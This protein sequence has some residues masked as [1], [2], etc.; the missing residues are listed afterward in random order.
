MTY[1][2]A[3]LVALA[4]A[5]LSARADVKDRLFDFTDAYYLQNGIDPAQIVNRVNGIPPRSIFDNPNFAFQRNVRALRLNPAYNHSGAIT[6]WTVMG[7]LFVESFTNN[8]AG[9]R[10]RQIADNMVLYVFPTRTGNPIGLGNNR[11]ADIVDMRNGYFSNNPLGLWLHVWVSYT[12]RAFNTSE[13]KKALD[14]LAK[15][16][17]LAL[18]GTPIIK[19]LSDLENLFSKGLAVKRFRNP[20]GSEGPMY[21]ICPVVKDPTDGG[22][23]QDNVLTVVRKTDG[24]PL[25]PAFVINFDSL[26]NTGNWA[27]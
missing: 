9:Q 26:K 20:N 19:T 11:Q 25:E 21:G 23:A 6:F 14:D 4:A 15:K 17:G 8:A 16:N 24:T 10:A 5:P 13:G 22:I 1:A 2:L 12:D 7:D 27:R 18:D 3:L